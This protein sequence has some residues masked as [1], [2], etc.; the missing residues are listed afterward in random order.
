MWVLVD[1]C[2]LKWKKRN[3]T[4]NVKMAQLISA[5][6]SNLNM[7]SLTVRGRAERC[8]ESSA[9]WTNA[10]V[11]R[12]KYLACDVHL[13]HAGCGMSLSIRKYSCAFSVIDP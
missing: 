12:A 13:P 8:K 7:E 9:L 4:V 11:I 3:Q 5:D 10:V 2:V 6:G 1:K